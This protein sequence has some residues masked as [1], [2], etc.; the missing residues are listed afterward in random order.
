MISFSLLKLCNLHPI[1]Q[2]VMQ[3]Q[4]AEYR[5]LKDTLNRIPSFRKPEQ[6]EQQNITQVAHSPQGD[7]TARDKSPGEPREVRVGNWPVVESF[8]LSSCSQVNCSKYGQLFLRNI[9][10]QI[11]A[12]IKSSPLGLLK[13]EE[14]F[15]AHRLGFPGGSAVKNPPAKAGDSGSIP[16]SRRSPRRRN[17]NPLQYSCLEN[18]MDRGAWWASPWGHKESDM[19]EQLNNKPIGSANLG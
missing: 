12:N 6:T 3:T 15:S 18:P 8:S 9:D 4:V 7:S 2:F 17:G 19:T 10:S 14:L 16:G 11:L 5:H 13:Q 1:V